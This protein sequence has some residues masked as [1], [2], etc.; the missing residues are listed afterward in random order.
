MSAVHFLD[1][2]VPGRR[3]QPRPHPRPHRRPPA[4]GAGHRPPASRPPTAR[5]TKPP[6]AR[7]TKPRP[8]T[9][10]PSTAR[11]AWPPTARHAKPS[12][13]GYAKSR[14]PAPESRPSSGLPSKLSAQTFAAAK[15]SGQ[16]IFV[17]FGAPWCGFSRAVKPAWQALREQF[18]G[19]VSEVDCTE[20]AGLCRENGVRG[21]PTMKLFRGESSEECTGMRANAELSSW[22]RNKLSS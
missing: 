1:N 5:Q 18:P 4:P 9:P 12:T 2:G 11:H 10:R 6:T 19:N 20:E 17:L 15:S 8:P 16:P 13:T 7:Q 14:P 22:L 3:F 21:Y